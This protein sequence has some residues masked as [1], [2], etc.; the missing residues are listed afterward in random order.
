M[1]VVS[2]LV[3]SLNGNHNPG[4]CWH[5]QHDSQLSENIFLFLKSVMNMFKV[6]E[7]SFSI[8]ILLE[9]A[10]YLPKCHG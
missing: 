5:D 7:I 3:G 10:P 1:Q 6:F 9:I 2:V 8:G 4:R